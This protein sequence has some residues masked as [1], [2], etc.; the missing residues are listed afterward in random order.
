MTEKPECLKCGRELEESARTGRPR[1]WC[2]VGCRRAAE[3]EVRRASR[4]LEKLE[5]RASDLRHSRSTIR[6]WLGRTREE[7]LADVEGELR[8]AE[9]RLRALLDAGTKGLGE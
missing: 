3:Y 5:E 7:A 9:E 6:D 2:S 8:E 1:S 4:R